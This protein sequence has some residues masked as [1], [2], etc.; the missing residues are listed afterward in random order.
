MKRIINVSLFMICLCT[1]LVA[2]EHVYVEPTQADRNYRAYREQETKPEFG[3][4]KV[5]S[6]I[7]KI[8][9][10]E[11]DGMIADYIAAISK[12][13]FK[14]LNLK[15]QFTYVMIHPEVYSQACIDDMTS[16]GEDQKIF[17]LLTFR[18]SGVDWSAD[19]YKFL[20]QNRDTV[21][22]LI[23][24]TIAVKKHM[25]VNLKSALVE[26]SAWESIPAMIRYYQTNRKDRDVLT[27][28]SLILKKEQY[29]PYLKSKMYGKLY[30]GDANYMTSVCF[31]TAN[32]QFLL[33]TAQDY[34]NQ[35]ISK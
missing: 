31:N 26:I 13:E 12:D 15:E 14:R 18:L 3:L 29:T 19:Q 32:E 9:E 34:Y 21:Q 4:R 5:E 27:V 10:P 24:E 17:G 25:G 22:T 6:L 30:L 2:Q 7:K 1:T 11:D 23:F 28:L 8:K 20:K 35:K 16:R 33:S